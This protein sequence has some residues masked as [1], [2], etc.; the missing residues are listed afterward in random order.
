MEKEKMLKSDVFV[1]SADEEEHSTDLPR[2]FH[3]RI[4][5]CRDVSTEAPGWSLTCVWLRRGV[6]SSRGDDVID[7][8]HNKHL[9]MMFY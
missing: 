6:T 4:S 8:G 1:A 3:G 7:H 5:Y 9:V 2:G